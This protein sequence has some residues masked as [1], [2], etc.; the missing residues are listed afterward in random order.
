MINKFIY[1]YLLPSSNSLTL[2]TTAGGPNI[3]IWQENKKK[4]E[5]KI[6]LFIL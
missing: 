5:K 3:V 2:F 1:L 6:K 4:K